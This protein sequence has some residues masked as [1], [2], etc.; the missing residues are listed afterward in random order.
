MT[1]PSNPTPKNT[2]DVSGAGDRY[3][4]LVELLEHQASQSERDRALELDQ[5]R[6]RREKRGGKPFLLVGV[7][8]L[9]TGWLWIW[10]PAFL[11][12]DPPPPQPLEQEEAAVRFA[13]YVQAQRI[14]AYRNETGSYPERLEEAGPPLPGMQYTRL[15][16]GLY[17]L[18]AETDRLALTYRSDL[19]LDD[20]VGS[21]ASVL[22]PD[23]ERATE[24]G[25]GS[26]PES[27]G[28]GAIGS[29]GGEGAP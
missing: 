8:L 12:M 29:P 16:E 7:L 19:P 3:E 25:S 26:A 10:P 13:M 15:A 14:A 23:L 22:P 27:G 20:F 18:T 4:A 21:G 17:Q 2:H 6:R 24:P 28:T 9:L 1:D 11:R 5:L